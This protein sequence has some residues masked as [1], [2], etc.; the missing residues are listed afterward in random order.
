MRTKK[1]LICGAS[2]FIGRNLFEH[3]DANSYET[4][5]TYFKNRPQV[6]S[7]R[8]IQVDLRDKDKALQIMRGMDIVINAAA[9]TAGIG[10]YSEETSVNAFVEANNRINANLTEAAHINKVG[11]FIFLSCTIMYPSSAVPLG[12]NESDMSKVHPKYSVLAEIK[13]LGEERCQYFAG[14]GPTKYTAVRHT[15]IYGPHDKFDLKCGHVLSATI[16]KVMTS[17]NNEVTVWGRGQESRDFLY[18][19][20]LIEFIR[21]AIDLQTN[22]F[23]IFNV[24]SGK[25]HSINEL[26]EII[27]S[28]SGQELKIVHDLTKPS[29]ET[30]MNIDVE[31]AKRLLGW[32]A[33]TELHKGVSITMEWYKQNHP[34]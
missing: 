26:V 4:Y 30:Q 23:E 12:E 5:G 19:K 3:F 21:R 33:Q 10:V 34:Q 22:N 20:D 6:S 1:V 27:I 25:T 11:H 13:I 32:E 31:K 18:I 16:E 7:P 17:R 8:I 29:V 2:G 28:H 24:G 9:M 14:I 15:N